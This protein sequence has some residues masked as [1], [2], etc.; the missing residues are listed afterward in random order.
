MA[1]TKAFATLLLAVNAADT[2]REKAVW[3]GNK[4]AAVFHYTTFCFR[5][6]RKALG[7]P[8]PMVLP[9]VASQ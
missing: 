1:G 4:T 9:P 2:S 5:K 3:T 7:R 6:E 8:E